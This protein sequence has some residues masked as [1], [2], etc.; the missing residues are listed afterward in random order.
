MKDKKKEDEKQKDKKESGQKDQTTLFSM[1]NI[2][3][4]AC[5]CLVAACAAFWLFMGNNNSEESTLK[6]DTKPEKKSAS[7]ID[8]GF[9]NIFSLGS[10]VVNLKASGGNRFLKVVIELELSQTALKEELKQR[11]YEIRDLVIVYLSGKSIDDVQTSEG[12]ISLR[13]GIIKRINQR[14]KTGK[15]K[16]LYFTEFI[17]Q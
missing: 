15:I 13:N 8:S 16:N 3:I 14:L 7:D 12:K 4:A 17:V 1:R 9:D 5:I 6:A 10:F 2:I 11:T